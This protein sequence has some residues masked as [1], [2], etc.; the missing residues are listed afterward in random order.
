MDAL[1]DVEA[2]GSCVPGCRG[3]ARRHDGYALD[4]CVRLGPVRVSFDGIVAVSDGEA[5]S[6]LGLTGY[7]R[8]GRAGAASGVARIRLYE[9]TVGCSLNYEIEAQADG[10]VAMLGHAMLTGVASR[11][12][13]LFASRFAGLF[14]TQVRHEARRRKFPSNPTMS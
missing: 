8:G 13:A 7:S 1:H 12:A 14:E 4:V 9:R 3:V 11:L 5:P 10:P 2:L 6:R